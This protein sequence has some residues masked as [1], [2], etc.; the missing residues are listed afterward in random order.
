MKL[1]L[2]FLF[3]IVAFSSIVA[4]CAS[5]VGFD[6][7]LFWFVLVV[8]AI[9]SAIFV[10]CARDEKRRRLAPLVPLPLAL[11]LC[12]PFVSIALLLNGLLLFLV[13]VFCACRPPL[14]VGTLWIV[15]MS[16]VSA[17]LVA[18]VVPGILELRELE[19]IREEFPIVPLE[20]RLSYENKVLRPEEMTQ[21]ALAADVATRLSE[22]ENNLSRRR[23][24]T[25]KFESIHAR[26]YEQFVRAVGF[27]VGRMMVPMPRRLHRPPL[28]D[29]PFDASASPDLQ[30][31]YGEWKELFTAGKSNDIQH[32]H[33]V[34]RRDFL[35]PDAFGA[36][37]DP[38]RRSVVGFVE[39][40]F[41]HSPL[42]GVE[43]QDE[44]AIVRLELVSL[45][46]FD[47]PRVY[48]LDHL[49]RMDQL[50]SDDVPTRSL[51][52][53]EAEALQQLWSKEDIVVA[54]VGSRHRM[55]GSLRA[56]AQ[57]LDCHDVSRGALLG[58]FSYELVSSRAR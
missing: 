42:H 1:S 51:D 39:H 47:E 25:Y 44:W 9:L 30:P 6:N 11:L 27:G 58:A 57:C 8:S 23:Y 50:A 32:L 35:D 2:K 3:L 7:G 46:K 5:R 48:V 16:T 54:E 22:T 52:R 37:V 13:G 10:Y 31:A 45:L 38:A 36:L 33:T 14:R 55:L 12:L 18:G 24:R 28:Q 4:W 19:T 41:H 21:N 53:F 34:S 29:I 43:D 40:G 49:P 20:S 15:A 26:H 17:S 56:A